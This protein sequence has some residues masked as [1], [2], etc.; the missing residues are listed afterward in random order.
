MKPNERDTLWR[1]QACRN[2]NG[3]RRRLY[4][5]K[6]DF[7]EE[8]ET[9]PSKAPLR[10]FAKLRCYDRVAQRFSEKS[11]CL[12]RDGFLLTQANAPPTEYPA[13]RA[14]PHAET[15]RSSRIPS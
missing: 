6:S 10:S 12:A 15:R 4:L 13:R 3:A 1:D 7:F 9:E 11:S 14:M 8:I 2:H 5:P